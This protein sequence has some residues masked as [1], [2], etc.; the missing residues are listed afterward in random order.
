MAQHIPTRIGLD[1]RGTQVSL[2]GQEAA[3]AGGSAAMASAAFEQYQA[4]T[5]ISFLASDYSDLPSRVMAVHT[6]TRLEETTTS[7]GAAHKSKD[8]QFRNLTDGVATGP[9]AFSVATYSVEAYLEA[10]QDKE[11][12]ETDTIAVLKVAKTEQVAVGFC[13]LEGLDWVGLNNMGG[14]ATLMADG[15]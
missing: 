12:E 9:A 15:R 14:R 1:G 3:A 10:G 11:G 2:T 5:K 7:G 13:T 6:S 8:K 4:A